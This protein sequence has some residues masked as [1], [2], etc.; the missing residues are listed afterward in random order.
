MKKYLFLLISFISLSLNAAD[1]SGFKSLILDNGLTVYLWEDKNQPDITGRL[2]VRAGSID[3]PLEY[4]GL[5]H[6]LEHL[7][8]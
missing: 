2:V 4:T 6:Y 3:E 1:I 7:L 8:F 5:A